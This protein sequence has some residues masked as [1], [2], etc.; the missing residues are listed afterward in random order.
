MSAYSSDSEPGEPTPP[1][2]EHARHRAGRVNGGGVNFRLV[3]LL[4][5]IPLI[6]TLPPMFY[7]SDDPRIGG[8][9]FFYWYQL[10]WIPISVAVTYLVYHA[11]RGDR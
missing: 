7:N 11:T 1:V 6:G 2:P 3:N 8:M 9:P 4:L 10:L 5:L